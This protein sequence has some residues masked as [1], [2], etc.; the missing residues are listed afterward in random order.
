MPLLIVVGILV[1]LVAMIDA[2]LRARRQ[3]NVGERH[4]TSEAHWRTGRD[5]AEQA[6]TTSSVGAQ[7]A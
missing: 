1:T 4:P 7:S 2:G 3:P 6:V 5:V